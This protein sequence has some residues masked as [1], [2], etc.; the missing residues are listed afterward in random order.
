MGRLLFEQIEEFIR[1]ACS[2][3]SYNIFTNVYIWFGI[4]WG[5]PVPLA[6]IY[7]HSFMLRH[8][9]AD[10]IY[11]TILTTPYQWFFVL[12]PVLF[13][14]IFGILGS[15]R[16]QKDL[17]TKRLIQ[18][19][20]MSSLADPLTGLS[21]RRNF[22][23][24]FSLEISRVERSEN[25]TS[26]L[27]IDIDHFKK[28]NDDYGHDMGDRIL[29]NTAEQLKSSCRIY[30]TPARWGGEEFILLL[31]TTTEAEAVTIAERIRLSIA[32][33]AT[34]DIPHVH[35]SIGVSQ[36]QKGETLT[37]CINRADQAM[38]HAKSTGRN[39]VVAWSSMSSRIVPENSNEYTC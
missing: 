12:H 13:G 8:E 2:W 38:Y 37:S 25:P 26:I 24:I 22:I 9:N 23:D 17:E 30:D 1:A 21:N 14:I 6:S 7:I 27:F 36:Y 15:V 39:R 20:K 28:I 34:S 18:E 19:L 33:D 5:L 32:E 29:Q 4:F 31:P 3:H 11:L 16:L 35:V 10:N